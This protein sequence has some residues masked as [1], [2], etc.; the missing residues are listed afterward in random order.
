MIILYFILFY[1]QI[2]TSIDY[3]Y[4]LVG[5]TKGGSDFKLNIEPKA[6]T[7]TNEIKQYNCIGNLDLRK[8]ILD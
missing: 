1:K 8:K 4:F 3:L 6:T 7:D 2:N 5:T